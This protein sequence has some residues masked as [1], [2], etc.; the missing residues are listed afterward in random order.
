MARES[1]LDPG[2]SSSLGGKTKFDHASFD[3]RHS[4]KTI[5]LETLKTDLIRPGDN[6]GGM[7]EEY[8]E[9]WSIN[10]IN[11]GI[12]TVCSEITRLIQ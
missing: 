8:S 12:F 1:T 5:A 6:V 3:R 2:V 4:R 10:D 9:T 7:L 11:G